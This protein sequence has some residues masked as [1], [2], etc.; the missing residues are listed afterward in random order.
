[1]DRVVWHRLRDRQR[2]ITK[3]EEALNDEW[4]KFFKDND[5]F[6]SLTENELVGL[7]HQLPLSYPRLH[8]AGLI[9]DRRKL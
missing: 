1:M 4:F 8:I 6:R 5:D 9:V 3:R 2:R 7:L